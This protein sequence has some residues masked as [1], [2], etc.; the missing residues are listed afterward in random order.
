M[1]DSLPLTSLSVLEVEDSCEY[2][3]LWTEYDGESLSLK[4]SDGSSAW[5]GSLTKNQL[6]GMAEQSKMDFDA[7]IADTLKALTRKN[8]GNQSFVYSYI[9]SDSGSLELVWKKHLLQNNVKFQMGGV[10]LS[11]GASKT[12]HRSFMD[13]AIESQEQMKE[14]KEK[15]ERL[16][17]ERKSAL[18]ELQH[19]VSLKDEVEKDLLSK[20]KLI[21]NE[22]KAKIRKL[23]ELKSHL[24]DQNEEM[25]R[26]VWDMKSAMTHGHYSTTEEKNH[27]TSA[28]VV[29]EQPQDS[30]SSPKAGTNVES[31][32][33]DLQCRPP[34]PPPA[35]RRQSKRV[36]KGRGEIPRPPVLSHDSTS[37]SGSRLQV[38]PKKH[39]TKNERD[40]DEGSVDSNE[41][42]DML[43]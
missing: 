33:G 22:K 20:F 36:G 5:Q 18:D 26:Q 24:T 31:L 4:L 8:M 9:V 12:I 41:L 39:V 21:L 6:R 30:C 10:D 1:A 28:A 17:S 19:R 3:Y 34:S 16:V 43:Q 2:L 25:Q 27:V 32:L 38:K 14:L 23:M 13:Y 11:P 15:S 29:Q 42:L 40:T 35:K 37:S 7:Y